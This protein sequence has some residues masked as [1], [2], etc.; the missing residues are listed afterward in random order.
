M[1]PFFVLFSES[2]DSYPPRRTGVQISLSLQ[3]LPFWEALFFHFIFLYCVFCLRAVQPIRR[4]ILGWLHFKSRVKHTF[5][6]C[7]WNLGLDEAT[8]TLEFG[9]YRELCIEIKSSKTG[10][11]IK[12]RCGPGVFSKNSR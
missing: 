1:E 10:K 7:I 11:R 2:L 6:Y 4:Q 3:R 9:V 12:N 5:S 8:S